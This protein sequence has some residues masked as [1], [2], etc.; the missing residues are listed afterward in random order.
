MWQGKKRDEEEAKTTQ[1]VSQL[2]ASQ[3]WEQQ[4]VGKESEKGRKK[5]WKE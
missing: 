4:A 2:V 3:A 5:H 1:S